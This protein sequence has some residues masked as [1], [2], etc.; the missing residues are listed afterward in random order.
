MADWLDGWLLPF[1][2]SSLC[3]YDLIAR[4]VEALLVFQFSLHIGNVA[5]FAA[6]HAEPSR[7]V[8]PGHMCCHV[9]CRFS[10][11]RHH[12]HHHQSLP[13]NSWAGRLLASCL[14]L[15]SYM[16]ISF[17]DVFF[18]LRFWYWRLMQ[19][20]VNFLVSASWSVLQVNQESKTRQ[21]KLKQRLLRE[22]QSSKNGHSTL[23]IARRNSFDLLCLGKWVISTAL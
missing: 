8:P 5:A 18:L 9:V 12:H 13:L 11:C 20:L 1:L 10:L 17:V 19:Q 6:C 23:W 3:L 15:S 16:W 14:Q 2:W 7:A 22:D 21:N 4:R